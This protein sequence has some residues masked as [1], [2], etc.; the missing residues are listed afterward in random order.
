VRRSASG[1]FPEAILGERQILSR[2][3]T[4]VPPCD[5]RGFA[6]ITDP[7]A[8]QA[9]NGLLDQRALQCAGP[10]TAVPEGVHGDDLRRAREVL[11]RGG[12]NELHRPPWGG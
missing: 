6:P 2:D 3:P 12:T 4:L 10:D 9:T 7:P 8:I 1:S 5:V 11:V